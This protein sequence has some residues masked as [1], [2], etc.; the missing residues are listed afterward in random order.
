[1]G[2]HGKCDARRWGWGWGSGDP[3]RACS[4]LLGSFSSPC[5]LSAVRWAAL[6]ISRLLYYCVLLLWSQPATTEI[7]TSHEPNI[8]LPYNLGIRYGISAS[9]KRLRHMPG[10]E[11]HRKTHCGWGV[12]QTLAQL[13]VISVLWVIYTFITFR[14]F[15]ELDFHNSLQNGSSS[16]HIEPNDRPRFLEGFHCFTV[17]N[18]WHVDFVHP[19]D[20]I[21]DPERKG[22]GQDSWVAA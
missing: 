11:C 14:P 5:F 15:E 12:A 8:K 9:W 13:F 17:G 7:C 2:A 22:K 3:L 6:L 19:Q 10:T 21:I 16:T 20:T 1:M 4:F 18:L